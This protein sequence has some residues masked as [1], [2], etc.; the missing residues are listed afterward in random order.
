ML[1]PKP[2][3]SHVGQISILLTRGLIVNDHPKAI[4]CLARTGY[5]R[6]SAYWFPFR[7]S[8]LFPHVGGGAPQLNR[9]G[10]PDRLVTDQFRP[11]HTFE[12]A[13]EF[14][15]FDK[16]LRMLISDALERIEVSVRSRMVE[17][18]GQ[19]SPLSHRDPANFSRKFTTTASRRYGHNG[20]P[21]TLYQDWLDRQ[22]KLFRRS[23]E[24][25]AE[26]FRAKYAGAAQHPAVWVSSET[27]DWG[28]LSHGF[29]G[30]APPD[31]H[32]I[33]RIFS[34]MNG[35]DLASWLRHLND[36]RNVCAH[37]SRLWNRNTANPPR[38][39]NRG[40]CALLDHL[41]AHSKST[42]RLYAGVA[43]CAYMMRALYPRTQWHT[44]F[45]DFVLSEAPKS[46]LIDSRVAGFP[47]R[48]H[49]EALWQ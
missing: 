28:V 2:Y 15:V 43:I 5:Y 9:V 24:D 11:G 7:I 18:L 36:I 1:Y 47:A 10:P 27:W 31:K 20:Q 25:F 21:L 45:R 40:S 30:L 23:K 12:D 3:T 17:H 34:N 41:H 22:D 44:R 16:K 42:R 29:D 19:K 35:Q 48:W 33:A 37:H 39:P 32:A 8:H 14:Y 4:V 46:Q 6:I 38:L 49:Q 13:V 26:H